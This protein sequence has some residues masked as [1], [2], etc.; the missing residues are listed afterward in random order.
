ML[1]MTIAGQDGIPVDVDIRGK[2][3]KTW[4]SGCFLDPAM[5]RRRF[6]R[7]RELQI[8]GFQDPL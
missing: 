1:T 7:V 6:C 8:Q 3:A 5:L 4:A 2:E